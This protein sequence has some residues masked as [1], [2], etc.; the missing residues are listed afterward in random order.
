MDQRVCKENCHKIHPGVKMAVTFTKIGIPMKVKK[1]PDRYKD[2]C[3]SKT[4]DIMIERCSCK[5]ISTPSFFLLKLLA[6]EGWEC[7]CTVLLKVSCTYSF[8]D[9]GKITA[10]QCLY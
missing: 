4:F 6:E 2:N 5:A 9:H 1:L 3:K 7:S 8:V 10:H